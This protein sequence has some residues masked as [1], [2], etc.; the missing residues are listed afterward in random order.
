MHFIH[1]ARVS[2]KDQSDRGSY[3]IQITNAKKFCHDEGILLDKEDI[4]IDKGKHGWDLNSK[5]FKRMQDALD[6]RDG[7]IIEH[8][9]RFFRG[10]P[11]DPTTIIDALNLYRAIFKKGKIVYSIYDKREL[12]METLMDVLMLT[13]KVYGDSERIVV[14]K[15]KQRD[16]IKRRI[17]NA[18]TWGPK[19]K[20]LNERQY[21]EL[22]AKGFT[23]TTCAKF[24][25]MSAVTLN[26]RL[27]ELQIDDFEEFKTKKETIVK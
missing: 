23:K 9:D 8:T 3:E 17:E 10:D 27:H 12:K 11:A 14:D 24:L 26:R 22:R 15:K 6:T 4:F 7:I 20:K 1:Y 13:V 5:E 16:G 19:I 21:R 25:G 18:G 2:T